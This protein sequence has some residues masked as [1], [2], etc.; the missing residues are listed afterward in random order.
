MAV[1]E[2]GRVAVVAIGVAALVT[3]QLRTDYGSCGDGSLGLYWDLAYRVGR[4][5]GHAG[6]GA[7]VQSSTHIGEPLLGYHP[8]AIATVH[9]FP[10]P[11]SRKT[12]AALQ[13]T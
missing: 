12:L 10:C 1:L 7:R 6:V 5:S 8:V 9:L 2:H 13:S 11:D 3:L 4:V